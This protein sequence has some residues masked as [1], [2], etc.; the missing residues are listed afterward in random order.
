MA[1]DAPEKAGTQRAKFNRIHVNLPFGKL[2]HPNEIYYEQQEEKRMKTFLHEQALKQS[3]LRS[4]PKIA[5]TNSR[6]FVPEEGAIYVSTPGLY[7]G[8]ISLANTLYDFMY[9][10]YSTLYNLMSSVVIVLAVICACL[11]TYEMSSTSFDFYFRCIFWI[12]VVLKVIAESNRPWLFWTGS[13]RL[14]NWFDFSL[15][16]LLLVFPSAAYLKGLRFV[17]PLW[18]LD[19]LE[20]ILAGIWN[21]LSDIFCVVLV[22]GLVMF[23]YAVI[24]VAALSKNDP[25]N[26]HNVLTA[27]TSM[28]KIATNEGW[29]EMFIVSYKGCDA[30]DYSRSPFPCATPQAS[31]VLAVVFFSSY[32]LFSLILVLILVTVIS[33]SVCMVSKAI[34]LEAAQ[35]EQTQSARKSLQVS[36]LYWK[37]QDQSVVYASMQTKCALVLLNIFEPEK[38][39]VASNGSFRVCAGRR[40]TLAHQ[41]LPRLKMDHSGN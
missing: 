1:D 41:N 36:R 18:H 21:I 31:P 7:R 13:R 4:R 2:K 19:F 32:V 8:Y 30:V 12:E 38:G 34:N 11:N 22:L 5:P 16:V 28:F 35:A 10:R 33:A 17:K 26:F 37:Y 15:C 6:D 23:M 9:G 40:R 29:E 14:W 27:M 20:P 39:S 24:G 3:I 25:M